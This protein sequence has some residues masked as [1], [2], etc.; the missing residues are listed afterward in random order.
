MHF[1]QS[2]RLLRI[3]GGGYVKAQPIGTGDD[4]FR[5]PVAPLEAFIIAVLRYVETFRGQAVAEY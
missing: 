5:Y 1:R 2:V 4:I 3:A